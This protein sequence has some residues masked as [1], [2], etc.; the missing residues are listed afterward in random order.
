MKIGTRVAYHDPFT[1]HTFIGVIVDGPVNFTATP[2]PKN[3]W[4]WWL[5]VTFSKSI[6]RGWIVL[7]DDEWVDVWGNRKKAA[8]LAEDVLSEA[9]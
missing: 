7:F 1:K 4:A 9:L 2:L 3:R 5:W 6:S 8:I